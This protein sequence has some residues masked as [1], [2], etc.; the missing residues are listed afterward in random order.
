M[1]RFFN[2][3]TSGKP[4]CRIP[5]SKSNTEIQAGRRSENVVLGGK[6][7]LDAAVDQLRREQRLREIIAL[8]RPLNRAITRKVSQGWGNA[9][10]KKGG[11]FSVLGTDFWD[12][13]RQ[14]Y[15]TGLWEPVGAS[16][17][18]LPQE[19]QN[20]FNGRR[21]KGSMLRESPERELGFGEACNKSSKIKEFS[22]S[23]AIMYSYLKDI[24]FVF[25]LCL[26]LGFAAWWA[27]IPKE[28][29]LYPWTTMNPEVV[30]QFVTLGR[31]GDVV[32][33]PLEG[34]D[35]FFF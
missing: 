33:P 35:P 8:K 4:E 17:R 12:R 15:I 10:L 5:L 11:A 2:K 16:I 31:V 23:E 25:L 13:Q 1:L 6:V 29:Y 21:G 32:S 34:F 18:Q 20:L 9:V 28:V 26:L 7:R 14:E 3:V 27:Y 24:I 19:I 30:N 22:L